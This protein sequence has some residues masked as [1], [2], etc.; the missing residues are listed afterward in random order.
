MRAFRKTAI[1]Q[2]SIM[3]KPDYIRTMVELQQEIEKLKAENE[4][5]RLQ[6]KAI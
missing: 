5:F 3:N 4:Q 2:L 1:I 6:M